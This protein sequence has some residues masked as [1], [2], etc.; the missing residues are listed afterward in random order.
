MCSP[1]P[2]FSVTLADH[3]IS[4]P[5]SVATAQPPYLPASP[6]IATVGLG[7]KDFAYCISV[8]ITW[9]R[10]YFG[11]YLLLYR[12]GIVI[13]IVRKGEVGDDIL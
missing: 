6:V 11:Y 2:S 8:I 9:I 7:V 1:L 3:R 10:T 13:V 5:Y 4:N 12:F